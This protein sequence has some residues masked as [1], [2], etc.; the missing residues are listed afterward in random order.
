MAKATSETNSTIE[1][2]LQQRAQY[3][4][5]LARLDSAGD[6]APPAVRARV[7]GDYESRLRGVIDELRTH[8]ATIAGELDRHKATQGGLDIERRQ[9]EEALAEAEVRHAVGEYSEDE[10]RKLS[11]ESNERLTG[12]RSEL[13]LVGEEIARLAEVQN[14]IGGA[15][16]RIEPPVPPPAPAPPV[17]VAP[18]PE[19]EPSRSPSPSRNRHPRHPLHHHRP[20]RAGR[21]PGRR[22]R[23][24]PR[25]PTGRRR[26]M[27]SRSSSRWDPRR[28]ESLRR[29]LLRR[30]AAATPAQP[31]RPPGAVPKLRRPEA[32]PRH[33]ERAGRPGW[34][35]RSSA[36]S[37]AR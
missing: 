16:K 11:D 6:K 18:V 2:L 23:E 34:P 8:A 17:A 24:S 4:Q 22:R 28:N 29:H 15:P 26:W 19:P 33:R 3:E 37:V 32:R 31:V 9:A 36:G 21:R 7:R 5:W 30:A 10:W 27:S 25:S 14:L 13:R 1:A 12:L 35:R 20:P